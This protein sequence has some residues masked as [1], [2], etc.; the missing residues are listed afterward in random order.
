MSGRRWPDLASVCDQCVAL[1]SQLIANKPKAVEPKLVRRIAP[2]ETEAGLDQVL[3]SLPRVAQAGA[4]AEYVLTR[5]VGRARQLGATWPQ[6]DKLSALQDS[7]PGNGSP[8]ETDTER[9]FRAC[10]V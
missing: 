8:G 7:P 6:S 2:W 1:C 3:A 9:L 5:Y 4:Q 10:P